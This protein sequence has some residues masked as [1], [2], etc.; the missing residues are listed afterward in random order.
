MRPLCP[1]TFFYVS[2]HGCLLRFLSD[3]VHGAPLPARY[4]TCLPP[5]SSSPRTRDVAPTVLSNNLSITLSPWVSQP[6]TPTRPPPSTSEA[7][8][9]T[10]HE[11]RP[12]S[13]TFASRI[14][15]PWM[16]ISPQRRQNP[17]AKPPRLHSMQPTKRTRKTPSD[18]LQT[19]L[20]QDR[21][22]CPQP[23]RPP[24]TNFA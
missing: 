15:E 19:A 8:C 5:C 12:H 4:R 13:L 17:V 23:H 10:S 22:T 16:S 11:V 7:P 2:Y 14:S 18:V 1:I 9:S 6:R 21:H 24:H 3:A 20:K